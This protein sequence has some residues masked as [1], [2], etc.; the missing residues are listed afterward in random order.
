MKNFKFINWIVKVFL[1]PWYIA[2]ALCSLI[3]LFFL[4]SIDA[5]YFGTCNL[6][7]LF[8]PAGT[9]FIVAAIYFLIKANET[10][11]G[12]GG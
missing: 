5:C 12:K 4:F 11:T 3:G 9:I 6:N 10:S 8:I 7:W 2:F 1:N